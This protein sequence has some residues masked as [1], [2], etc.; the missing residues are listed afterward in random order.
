MRS[1]HRIEL[2]DAPKLSPKDGDV[3]VR[4]EYVS[5]CGSDMHTY[6]RV[7]P[8]EAYPLT[9]GAPLHEIIGIVEQ[10]LSSKIKVGERVIALPAG[11]QAGGAEYMVTTGSRVVP[12]PKDADPSI[13]LMCQPLGTIVYSCRQMG[14]VLGQR[15][16]VVGQGPIGLF[17][18]MLLATMG[19]TD[20]IA[21]DPLDYRLAYSMKHGATAVVNPTKEDAIAAVQ[22]LTGGAGADVVIEASGEVDAFS[23]VYD[24]VKLR[25]RVVLFG[26]PQEPVVPFNYSKLMRK[27]PT[28]IPTVSGSSGEETTGIAAT[29]KLVHDKRLDPSWMITHRV[30]LEDAPKAYDMYDKH[31]DGILKVVMKVS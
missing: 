18:T 8:E 7:A 22:R 10:S 2:V 21:I 26:L 30:R 12:V 20:V 1:P 28:V 14:S 31:S 29:V 23:L 3:L 15:V 16:A 19:A 9:P 17:F 13:M 24:L 5:I 6:R 25:G 4:A 11:V 27:Q